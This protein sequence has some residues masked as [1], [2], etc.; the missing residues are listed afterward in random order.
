MIAEQQLSNGLPPLGT[1]NLN[2]KP[3]TSPASRLACTASAA[4]NI[5]LIA[6]PIVPNITYQACLRTSQPTTTA[7]IENSNTLND[8]YE[9]PLTANPHPPAGFCDPITTSGA[10]YSTL[11]NTFWAGNM[12]ATHNTLDP[13]GSRLNPYTIALES[14]KRKADTSGDSLSMAMP[15]RVKS[16]R[17]A[18][19]L[20]EAST[21]E[22][23]TLDNRSLPTVQP[24]DLTGEEPPSSGTPQIEA[25]VVKRNVGGRPRTAPPKHKK[26][27]GPTRL[28][29]NKP[30]VAEIHMDLWELILPYCPLRFLFT[31]RKVNTQFR[32]RL[33][34]G[35]LWKKCRIQNYGTDLPD[36]PKGMKEWDYANLLEGI[37]CMGCPN[38]RTRKTYWAFQKRWC[39]KCLGNNT[40]QVCTRS[41]IPTQ[42]LRQS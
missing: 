21:T 29:K 17:Q 38:K 33:A 16:G 40:V 2:V 20:R 6:T 39:A 27:V 4:H 41:S 5:P 14:F 13:E 35:S 11:G 9:A 28:R 8:F 32:E 3:D 22:Q 12:S 37:G 7:N 18:N 34:Y 19:L 42:K 36:P 24:T 25:T 31:A 26:P 23:Q 15:K 1:A 30:V 10:T